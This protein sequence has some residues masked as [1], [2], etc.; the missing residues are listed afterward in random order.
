MQHLIV[1][2][3]PG[4]R[5]DAIINYDDTE[6]VCFSIQRQGDYHGPDEVQLWCVIGTE[7]ERE[8]FDKREFVPHWLDVD[9]IEADALDVIEASSDMAV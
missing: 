3:D 7:D 9:D 1:H 8:A 5:K 2:G 6:Q 4:I